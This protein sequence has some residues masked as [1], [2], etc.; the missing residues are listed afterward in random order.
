[1][2]TNLSPIPT[3]EFV[4]IAA[5]GEMGDGHSLALRQDGTIVVWGSTRHGLVDN[6][7]EGN[8][9]VA[10]ATGIRHCLALRRNGTIV[11][12]GGDDFSLVSDS[13]EGGGFAVIAAGGFNILAIRSII[14]SRR[15]RYQCH[16]EIKP[17]GSSR[18]AI[19]RILW[20]RQYQNL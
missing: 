11:S 4:A 2:S 16:S 5:G 7:P 14:S 9:F 15:Y 20:E 8:D 6:A 1:M 18:P 3:G 17:T 13:P 10:V 12:W 19:Y